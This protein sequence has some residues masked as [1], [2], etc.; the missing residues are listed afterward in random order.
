M[1]IDLEP[2]FNNEGLSVS[3][4]YTIDLSKLSHAG[5]RPL[6]S[7]VRIFGCV[8]NSTG[9]VSADAQAKFTYEALCDR[10]A[11]GTSKEFSLPITHGIIRSPANEG[12][13]DGEYITAQDMRLD[14]DAVALEDIV[15]SLPSKFLCKE[16]CK[17][18]CPVCGC[19]L[20][21]DQCNCKKPID[22]R[23]EGLL[24]FL[25]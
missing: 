21:T 18:L 8:K 1:V 4:D 25:E 22:P 11:K 2:I 20:N 14:F 7:P 10:C 9:I 24:Q 3:F 23:L 19:D 16:S 17:G 12:E 6:K 13:D 5:V 15:L